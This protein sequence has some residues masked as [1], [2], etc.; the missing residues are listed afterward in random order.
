VKI[1]VYLVNYKGKDIKALDEGLTECFGKERT[2]AST[3]VGVQAQA[4]DG[5]LA[6]VEAIAVVE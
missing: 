1:N 5:M 3:V 6:E 4:R 2:F